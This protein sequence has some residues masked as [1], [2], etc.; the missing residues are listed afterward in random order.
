MD[1]ASHVAHRTTPRRLH[2]W[3]MKVPH[4][5]HGYPS[6][7][8]SSLPQERH[9]IRSVVTEASA[10][11]LRE[12]VLANLLNESRAGNPELTRGMRAIVLMGLERAI[13]M[14]PLDVRQ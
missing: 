14:R 3:Q 12:V 6:D 13:N 9:A 10:R 8:R 5:W 1:A 4:C 7:A 2:S 11:F